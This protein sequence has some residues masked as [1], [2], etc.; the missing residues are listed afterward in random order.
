MHQC[1][2]C[3]YICRYFKVVLE[4]LSTAFLTS[5]GTELVLEVEAKY[6]GDR[7]ASLLKKL[8]G[9][10]VLTQLCSQGLFGFG[11]G[12]NGKTLGT[13]LFVTALA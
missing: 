11:G 8:R 12:E 7:K 5:Y 1:F 3:R 9:G 13:R 2:V 6:D 10:E 4:E